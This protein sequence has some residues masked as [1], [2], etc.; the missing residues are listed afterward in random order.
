MTEESEESRGGEGPRSGRR[1]GGRFLTRFDRD[2]SELR[3]ELARWN[4]EPGG[5]GFCGLNDH[6]L[7]VTFAGNTKR[8]EA[9]IEDGPRYEGADFPGAVTF[10][11]ANQM[12][13]AW[14][15]G[16]T[17]DYATIKLD[18]GRV[19]LLNAEAGNGDV[20]FR[21]FTNRPDPFVHQMAL[22]LRA[23][24]R[25]A[26]P[27]GQL[28]ADSV[29]TALSWH[30]IRRFSTL[31]APRPS[32][33]PRLTGP[34]LGRVLD[35]IREHLSSDLRLSRLSEVAGMDRYHFSRAFKKATGHSPHR[36]VVARRVERAAELLART[37]L[38]IADVAY[39]VGLS[40]QSHLTTVFR[41]AIGDTPH[42]YRTAR[43]SA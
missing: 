39:Q 4:A 35:H 37:D 21:G 2:W 27:G 19:A 1:H 17:I 18:P 28:F 30:L 14:H 25:T 11:P 20:E 22:A 13:H 31:A 3:L 10:I 40:S 8:T 34:R 43:R 12:R 42:A 36:Y 9:T 16:G 23:E 7:F 6:L 38:P 15:E 29:A 24:A 32:G 5:N 33:Q 26:D 41:K